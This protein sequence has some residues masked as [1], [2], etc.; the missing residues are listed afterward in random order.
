MAQTG[1]PLDLAMT[2]PN[3]VQGALEG[4]NVQPILETTRM[5]AALREFQFVSQFVQ[6]ESDRQ[7]ESIDRLLR[8]RQS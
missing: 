4:Y 2:Q 5:M 6:S 3:I 7:K 1:N 8:P